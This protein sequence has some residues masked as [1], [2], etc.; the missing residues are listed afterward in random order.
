VRLDHITPK[1]FE[2]VCREHLHGISAIDNFPRFRWS[3]CI[4]ALATSFPGGNS[5]WEPPD[6]IP[7]SEVKL[8]SA[9]GSVGLPHVRVGHC[10][11]L[12][13]KNPCIA[14]R[15]FFFLSPR[16]GR[17]EK[18]SCPQHT[19]VDCHGFFQY[20]ARPVWSAAS[21]WKK[22]LRNELTN[23]RFPVECRPPC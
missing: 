3:L 10:Q 17:L 8:L 7:N 13:P 5:K 2:V 11:D 22:V 9:D 16:V 18:V 4:E 1:W 19:D 20:I 14:C 15:G 23:M 12:I 6:P 21:A